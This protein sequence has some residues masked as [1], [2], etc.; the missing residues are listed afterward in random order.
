[1]SKSAGSKIRNILST[2]GLILLALAIASYL[3][4]SFQ[5]RKGEQYLPTVFGVTGVTI[6]TGS[7]TP[8]AKVGDYVLIKLPKEED[9]EVGD[10]I[11]FVD[12]NILV[13][14]RVESI[15]ENDGEIGFITKGD[16]NNVADENI[17]HA[18]NIVGVGVLVIPKLGTVL[19]WVT[20]TKG[21][22][23]IGAIILGL[24]FFPDSK[25][26]KKTKIKE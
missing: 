19:Q 22:I 1:M 16:A 2:A 9:I 14:H 18:N 11:T 13:T 5:V 21:L 8:E 20:S 3:Y 25:K 7:M 10:I 4:S 17:V 26:K 12:R 23:I 15:I 6:Q 24:V